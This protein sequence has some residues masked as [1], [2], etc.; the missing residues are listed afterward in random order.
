MCLLCPPPP[1]AAAPASGPIPR[2]RGARRRRAGPGPS[3]APPP[4]SPPAARWRA[5]GPAA[6][7][8]PRPAGLRGGAPPPTS[9]QQRRSPAF[10]GTFRPSSCH[11]P[12]AS[13]DDSQKQPLDGAQQG[14]K[15]LRS[16]ERNRRAVTDESLSI[17]NGKHQGCSPCRMCYPAHLADAASNRRTTAG[18]GGKRSTAASATATASLGDSSC[19]SGATT[20]TT[21]VTS[22]LA[23]AKPSN[24]VSATCKTA[25]G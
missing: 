14:T 17:S 11:A 2:R 15:Y 21:S 10:I 23:G 12:R 19:S 4:A 20:L 16:E 8:A 18:V 5:T 7:Q 1:S 22:G 3:R 9:P 13:W 24:A 25:A 6:P